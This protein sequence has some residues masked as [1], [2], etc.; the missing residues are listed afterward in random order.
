MQTKFELC[1]GNSETSFDYPETCPICKTSIFPSIIY[2]AEKKSFDSFLMIVIFSCPKCQDIFAG[3]Y[4]LTDAYMGY[5]SE[6]KSLSPTAYAPKEFEQA[7]NDISP[8]FVKIYNQASHAESLELDKICGMGYRKS[9]EFL[10]KDFAC[11]EKPEDKDKIQTMPLLQC[12]NA[13]IE[14]EHLKSLAIAAVWLGNDETH[15][16]RKHIDYD[17]ASLKN[18]IQGIVLQIS[19]DFIIKESKKL[20]VKTT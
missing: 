14:N 17:I 18:F 11:I 7:I 3:N 2:N 4:V 10:V 19:L 9:L 20:T 16:S 15:Y 13:Y 5:D 6:L 8:K 1:T 12:I